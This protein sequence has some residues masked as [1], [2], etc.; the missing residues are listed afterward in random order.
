MIICI[1]MRT[2]TG[3]RQ[4][5]MILPGLVGDSMKFSSFWQSSEC[6]KITIHKITIT[7]LRTGSI[8]KT[9]SLKNTGFVHHYEKETKD[10]IH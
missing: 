8:R 1:M 3:K 6:K 7:K 2:T 10:E 4:R 9:T 5:K